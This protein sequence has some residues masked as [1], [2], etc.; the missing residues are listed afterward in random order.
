MVKA[1][2]KYLANQLVLCFRWILLLGPICC[3]KEST[4]IVHGSGL[5]PNPEPTRQ[6]QVVE[7]LTHCRPPK[8]TDQ[9]GFDSSRRWFVL[10]QNRLILTV[11]ILT[12][13]VVKI[14]MDLVEI[15]TDLIEIWMDLIEIWPDLAEFESRER[16]NPIRS[17]GLGFHAK[18]CQPT[19]RI[20]FLKMKIC[21]QWLVSQVSVQVG[22]F[23][24]VGWVAG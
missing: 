20:R 10:G 24:W 19:R 11:E 23:G 4:R 16:R 2:F 15:W 13:V 14:L 18:T 8:T 1:R 3:I 9:I 5:C 21:R 22:R 12:P 6:I 7:K 17:I